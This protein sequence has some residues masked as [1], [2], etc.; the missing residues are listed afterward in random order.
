MQIALIAG[1]TP[2]RFD[3]ILLEDIERIQMPL[4]AASNENFLVGVRDEHGDM[5][6]TIEIAGARNL[7]YLIAKLRGLGYRDEA[8]NFYEAE[9]GFDRVVKVPKLSDQ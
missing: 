5:Y 4:E 9:L 2:S 1:K 3:R 8:V 7:A 6:R